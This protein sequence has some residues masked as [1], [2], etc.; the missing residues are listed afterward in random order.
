MVVCHLAN[1]PKGI[2]FHGKYWVSNTSMF[3]NW[4]KISTFFM[5]IVGYSMHPQTAIR[6]RVIYIDYI[7]KIIMHNYEHFM[8]AAGVRV[9]EQQRRKI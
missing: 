9:D 6:M 7:L 1:L 3:D 5:Q 4:W 2:C 8:Y